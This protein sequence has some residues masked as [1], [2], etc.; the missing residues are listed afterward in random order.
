MLFKRTFDIAFHVVAVSFSAPA[1]FL[2]YVLVHIVVPFEVHFFLL[3]FQRFPK[4]G[5]YESLSRSDFY[6]RMQ[7]T[8][9]FIVITIG[10]NS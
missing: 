9:N 8:L 6:G 2:V 4:D 10:E 5:D 3:R 7:K 1:L